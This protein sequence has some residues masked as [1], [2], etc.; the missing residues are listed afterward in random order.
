MRAGESLP[1]RTIMGFEWDEGMFCLLKQLP[2]RAW[3][4][5]FMPVPGMAG[6]GGTQ[7]QASG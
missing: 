4:R 1:H 2:H 3:L 6:M 7:G 5:A